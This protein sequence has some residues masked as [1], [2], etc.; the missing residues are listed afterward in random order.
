MIGLVQRVSH[1]RVDVQQQTIATI[2]Q[3]IC[4]LVGIEQQDTAA[5]ADRLLDRMLGYRI[6]ADTGGRMNLSLIDIQGDL[7]LVPQFTLSADTN[8][9]MR[10]SFSSAAPAELG[11][12][13]FQYLIEQARL[14][15]VKVS[16]GQFGA[17]MQVALINDGPVT[18]WLQV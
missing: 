8:K 15:Y 18:F 16:A 12:Q 5:K 9:G 7:L 14:K 11:K 4:A 1:A 3:G 10:P 17:D 13:L 2:Q 6:F